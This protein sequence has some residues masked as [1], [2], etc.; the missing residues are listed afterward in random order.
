MILGARVFKRP[1][2]YIRPILG[3]TGAKA[4]FDGAQPQHKAVMVS[5][6]FG[7]AWG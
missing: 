5:K 2:E 4:C 1:V 7:G 3:V 6:A